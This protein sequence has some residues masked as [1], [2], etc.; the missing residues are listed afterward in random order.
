MLD[1]IR[2]VEFG[3]HQPRGYVGTRAVFYWSSLASRRCDQLVNVF[4]SPD[5]D[6]WPK[7]RGRYRGWE[8]SLLYPLPP[9][10]SADGKDTKDLV[11]PA[12]AGVGEVLRGIV[13]SHRNAHG[14]SGVSEN[15]TN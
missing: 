6:T 10:G 12:E 7:G 1:F 5:G 2:K 9:R 11:D 14:L 3:E 15:M 4:A 13:R 8:A